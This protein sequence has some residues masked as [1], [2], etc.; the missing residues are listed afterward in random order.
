MFESEKDILTVATASKL[1]CVSPATTRKLINNGKLRH[2]K[3][4]SCVRIR[5]S[6]LIAFIE[7]ENKNER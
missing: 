6:D 7:E 5:K 1:L 3:I 2:K 4:G